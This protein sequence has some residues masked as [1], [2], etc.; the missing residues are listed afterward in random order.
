MANKRTEIYLRKAKQSQ[1]YPQKS[2]ATNIA[3]IIP[4]EED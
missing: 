3:I 1:N 2:M 4:R